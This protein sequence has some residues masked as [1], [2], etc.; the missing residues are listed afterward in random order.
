[1]G[2]LP[3]CVHTKGVGVVVVAAVVVVKVAV[4]VVTLGV[5]DPWQ[6]AVPLV[7]HLFNT[8]SNIVVPGQE[9]G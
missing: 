9:P 2:K 8:G 3:S 7:T 6:D 4:V 5:V 1:M